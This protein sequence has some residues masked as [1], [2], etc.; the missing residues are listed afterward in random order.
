MEAIMQKR[1]VEWLSPDQFAEWIAVD[2]EARRKGGPNLQ[3]KYLK[4][5]DQLP[6]E[7]RQEYRAR[8]IEVWTKVENDLAKPKP[9]VWI[10]GRLYPADVVERHREAKKA[11]TSFFGPKPQP[12]AEPEPEDEPEEEPEPEEP[13]DDF[14]EDDLQRIKEAGHK[15]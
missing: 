1:A 7:A 10:N 8:T 4:L 13:D 15:L 6:E 3:D 5:V 2:V 12:S 14:V 9:M 11:E